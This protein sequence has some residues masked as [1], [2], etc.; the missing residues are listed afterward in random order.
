[1]QANDAPATVPRRCTG[2]AR[3]VPFLIGVPLTGALVLLFHPAPDP[4]HVHA[5]LADQTTRWLVV[6]GLTL[7][8]IGLMGAALPL[9]VRHLPGTAARVA[10]V[11]AAVFALFYGTGEAILESPPVCWSGTASRRPRRCS[12]TTSSPGTCCF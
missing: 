2:A 10:G 3:A 1:V 9:L 11:G 5:S 6:H 4:R 12:G 8:F 7:V